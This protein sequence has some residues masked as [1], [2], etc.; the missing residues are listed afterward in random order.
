MQATAATQHS[1]EMHRKNQRAGN[2]FGFENC[3]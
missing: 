3:V 2:I 1:G